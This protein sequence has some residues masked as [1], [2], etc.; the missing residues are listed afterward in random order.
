MA[1]GLFYLGTYLYKEEYLEKSR[2]MLSNMEEQIKKEP[3]FH[4]NW[5]HLLTYFTH[6]PYEVAIVGE[7]WENLRKEMD[8][9]FLP[10]VLYL[11]G[12][13]EGKLELLKF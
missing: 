4:S 5:A 3:A 1:K 12:N 9:N 8:A 13:S 10:N 2:Q 11:G 6:P 7:G